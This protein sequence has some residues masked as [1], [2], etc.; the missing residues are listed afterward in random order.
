MVDAGAAV[1]QKLSHRTV[2]AGRG[3]EFDIL[4]AAGQKHYLH[5]LILKHLTGDNLEPE[6]PLVESKAISKRRG[7]DADMIDGPEI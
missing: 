6:H 5:P 7:R 2:G 4:V 1:S 3:Q